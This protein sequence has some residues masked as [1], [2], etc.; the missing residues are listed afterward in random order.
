MGKPAATDRR[1]LPSLSHAFTLDFVVIG[2]GT[3]AQALEM[4]EELKDILE[5]IDLKLSEEKT[6]ITHIT[7]GFQ[8]LGYWI[9]RSIG[10]TGKDGTKGTHTRESHQKIPAQNAG[11][12]RPRN[13]KR[14]NQC[15]DHRTQQTHNR[16]VPILQTYKGAGFSRGR[17]G[18]ATK[19]RYV[20]GI[21]RQGFQRRR[22]PDAMPQRQ[23]T[24]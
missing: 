5:N 15:K 20:F 18:I 22:I 16:G 12:P 11:N 14:V 24:S 17:A 7:E 13:H 23:H 21:P 9:E 1:C 8:F 4:K 3:K 2:N 19:M 10:G 6:K